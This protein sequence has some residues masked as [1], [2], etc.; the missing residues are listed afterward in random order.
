[1]YFLQAGVLM[2]M[3]EIRKEGDKIPPT[4][5]PQLKYNRAVIG[6][7]QIELCRYLESIDRHHLL[8]PAEIPMKKKIG[9]PTIE[10][11]KIQ[12]KRKREE[13]FKPN[14]RQKTP[15]K[16]QWRVLILSLDYSSTRKDSEK[17]G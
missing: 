3:L 2:V 5:I 9:R 13:I 17:K 12:T 11:E 10:I 4:I 15:L 1:M 6:K 16:A 7:E 8:D 14:K